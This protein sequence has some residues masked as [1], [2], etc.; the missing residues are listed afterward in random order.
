MISEK[1]LAVGEVQTA[2]AVATIKGRNSRHIAK[3]VI[4]VYKRRVR[5]NRRR[6]TK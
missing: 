2:A 4:G 5:G 1:I 3:K 6:L